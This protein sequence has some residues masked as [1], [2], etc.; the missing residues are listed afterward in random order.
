[1]FLSS[2]GAGPFDS[3]SN[4][5]GLI[6]SS[7]WEPSRH[8]VPQDMTTVASWSEDCHEHKPLIFIQGLLQ[9]SSLYHQVI[10]LSLKPPQGLHRYQPSSPSMPALLIRSCLSTVSSYNL[11]LKASAAVTLRLM[12]RADHC[13]RMSLSVCITSSCA[14]HMVI[15]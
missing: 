14:L 13:R 12:R 5:F 15:Q 11:K 4:L 8:P 6:C 1:M 9:G 3:M 7:R 10:Q 2:F